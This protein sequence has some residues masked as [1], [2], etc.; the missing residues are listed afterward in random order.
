MKIARICIA[1]GVATAMALTSAS[2]GASTTHASRYK[3]PRAATTCHTDYIAAGPYVIRNDYWNKAALCIHTVPGH[4]GFTVVK[5]VTTGWNIAYPMILTGCS[6]GICSPHSKL[7]A[8]VSSLRNPTTSLNVTAHAGGE[9]NAS[10]DIW[11]AKHPIRTGMPDGAEI[12]IWLNRRATPLAS[13]FQYVVFRGTPF[14]FTSWQA[15]HGGKTWHYLQFRL[16]HPSGYVNLHLADFTHFAEVKGMLSSRWYMLNIEAGFELW[17][18]GV[19]LSVN[20][21]NANP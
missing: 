8:R 5:D 13:S 18:G 12:M 14:W 1:V 10:Y 9:W 15:H 2:A 17:H 20:G 16:V 11:F 4:T 7:P 6:W 19:G 3:P 21:F